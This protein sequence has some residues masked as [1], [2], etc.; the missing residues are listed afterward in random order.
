MV[1]AIVAAEVAF[2]MLLIGGLSVRYLL[3]QNI[4]SSWLLRCVPLVDV[5]LL[6]LVGIDVAGGAAPPSRTHA[7]AAVHLGITVAFGHPT[8]A[9]ADAH[10]RHRFAGG[11]RPTKP[12]RGSRAEVR[13]LW[14]EWFRVVGA[15]AIAT[16]L[17]LVLIAVQGWHVPASAEELSQH[18]CWS[19]I[20]L[21]GIVTA[22]W[23]PAFAGSGSD[24]TLLEGPRR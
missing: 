11:P 13:A 24:R 2:R 6:V 14:K 7:E 18:P 1:A 8:I 20:G 23:F 9:W 17:I 12:A 3:R 4:L 19:M 21:A 16:S 5:A 10:F 22:I 15:T